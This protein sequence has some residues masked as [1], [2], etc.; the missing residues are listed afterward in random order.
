MCT[1]NP[2]VSVVI[3][4][5]NR[6][7]VLSRAL[8]SV[9]HQDTTACVEVIV[10]DDGSDDGTPQVVREEFPQSSSLFKQTKA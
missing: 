10:V 6:R 1:P 2:V 3:P 8:H 5:F 4:T 7:H 9:L